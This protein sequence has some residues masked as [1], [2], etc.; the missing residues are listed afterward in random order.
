MFEKKAQTACSK[1]SWERHQIIVVVKMPHS[2]RISKRN[3]EKKKTRA[4]PEQKIVYWFCEC[5]FFGCATSF[6]RQYRQSHRQPERTTKARQIIISNTYIEAAKSGSLFIVKRIDKMKWNQINYYWF[7]RFVVCY[8]V[9]FFLSRFSLSI[10]L[11]LSFVRWRLPLAR[12]ERVL[13]GENRRA[14]KKCTQH[15]SHTKSLST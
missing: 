13:N 12:S 8:Q 11:C 6:R 9:F 1:V 10:C 2:M 3:K 14:P 5:E 4:T 15:Y 7:G